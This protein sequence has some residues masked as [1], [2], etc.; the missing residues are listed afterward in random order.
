MKS[1][2]FKI[3]L[4]AFLLYAGLLSA[5]N[6]PLKTARSFAD[7]KDYKNA[8]NA[9]AP[10]YKQNP[11]NAELY[12]EYLN[13]LILAKDYKT[14]ANLVEEQKIIRQNNPLPFIDM[15]RV[16]AA[17]SKQKKAEEQFDMAVQL[18]NGDD[19]LTQQIAN[20][21]TGM[22]REDYTLKTYERARDLIHSSYMYSGP[23][24]RLYAKKGDM[25][26]AIASLLD[27]GLAFMANSAEDTK[28]T[29]LE[30]LGTD[31]KKLQQ[32][33][34]ALVKRINEQPENPYYEDLL[35]WLYTQKD[36]WEGAMIQMQALDAR[37]RETGEHM[38]EFARFAMKEHKPEFAIKS[39]DAVIEKGPSLPF[40]S[41]ARNEKLS[42]LFELLSDSPSYTKETIVK[43]ARGYEELLAEFPQ[44]YVSETIEDYAELEAIYAGNPQKA[45]D[46][47]QKAIDMPS[48]NRQLMG[49]CKLQMGDYM[50]L[51]GK[52]W[53][54][55]L[56]YSQVD[57]SFRE[58][59]LGEEARFR[60]AKLSYYQG[61]FTWADG[62]LS[63]LKASTS[64]L[65]ANDALYLSV[66]ITENVTEDSNYIPIKRFAYADLLLFQNKDKEAET[67]LDSI[68][69]AFP[70]HPLK[71]DILMKKAMLAQKHRE[72]DKAISF[73]ALIHDKYGQDVL[74]DD[75]V[76]KMA[77][78]YQDYLAKP[79][80]AKKN[81]EMLIT[82]YPGSTY[83]HSARNRLAALQQG[84]QVIP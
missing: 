13:V 14:A 66:L 52:V 60:N 34:K 46:L 1:L 27:G 67:L 3:S 10:L 35:T 75:A 39:Y 49:Q 73:L 55:S 6:D 25:D 65:I 54:A 81:Y 29:L 37:Q 58:D 76:F 84:N 30:I 48:M 61:D 5:Q 71:D 62:Q 22:G 15:G 51:T 69:N 16:Y 47:L 20:T 72:Y 68:S 36:D 9:Y 17:D 70:E 18:I 53:D 77:G 4:L 63:V 56:I 31:A 11:V 24:A 41:N 21:F 2:R 8:A 33:Q 7:A 45:I 50:I 80:I 42:V 26:K 40:Y 44:Y 38:I 79:E 82:E 83:I 59:V 78:I 23:L 64:E 32:A 12:K 28:A 74:G 57:K 19:I 43:L